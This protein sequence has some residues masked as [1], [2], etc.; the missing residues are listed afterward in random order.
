MYVHYSFHIFFSSFF[1]TNFTRTHYED[2]ILLQGIF[3]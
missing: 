2:D 3:K 1:S